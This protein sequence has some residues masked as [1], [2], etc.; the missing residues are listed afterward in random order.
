ME[1]R[2]SNTIELRKG[3]EDVC[4]KA[5]KE[6]ADIC[7]EELEKIIYEDIYKKYTPKNS[8]TKSF[9]TKW[10][11]AEYKNIFKIRI[12]NN[13]GK[14]L[15]FSLKLNNPNEKIPTNPTHFQHGAGFS[16]K[17]GDVIYSELEDIESYLEMLNDPSFINNDNPFGFPRKISREPFWDEF[18]EWL[19]NNFIKIY[20]EIMSKYVEMR[21]VPY[22]GNV[23]IR[24]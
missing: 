6:T 22:K 15:G 23:W 9:R 20:G 5:L 1:Y 24:K 13:F 8:Q 11:L 4:R 3:V 18:E 19:E 10:L 17:N 14:G 2:F 21:N 12:Y 7:M 16:G